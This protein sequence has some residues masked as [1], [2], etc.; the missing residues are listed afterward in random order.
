MGMVIRGKGN[1]MNVRKE[2]VVY[3]RGRI[4]IIDV[5]VDYE[6]KDDFRMIRRRGGL[7]IKVVE[8]VKIEVM[9]KRIEDGEGVG[10][11]YVLMNCLWK[12]KGLV[13]NVRRKM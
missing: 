8:S 12:K 9:N 4:D 6:V 13:G 11:R 2:V 5:G 7:V 3:F 10:G 1:I